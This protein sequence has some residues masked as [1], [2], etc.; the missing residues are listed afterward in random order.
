V[1]VCGGDSQILVE[2]DDCA[3]GKFSPV[4]CWR[5]ISWSEFVQLMLF[6]GRCNVREEI[7]EPEVG[8]FG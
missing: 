2:S 7:W 3:G 6:H 8:S 5:A 4:V 1:D